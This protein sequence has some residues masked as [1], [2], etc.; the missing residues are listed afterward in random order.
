MS[1]I[2]KLLGVILVGCS[3]YILY[4]LIKKNLMAQPQ[5]APAP[6]PAPSPAPPLPAPAPSPAPPTR[7]YAK[8]VIQNLADISVSF[9]FMVDSFTRT[10]TLSYRD[11]YAT[12]VEAN[13]KVVVSVITPNIY[14]YSNLRATGVRTLGFVAEE[15][16]EY[17]MAL[18]YPIEYPGAPSPPKLLPYQTP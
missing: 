7:P 12:S 11:I 3:G 13:K 10:I 1:K 16:A 2:R 4:Q 17:K 5:P 6:S 14:I 18:D 9:D 8:V 15:G